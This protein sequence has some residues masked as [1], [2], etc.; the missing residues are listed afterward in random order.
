MILIDS[1]CISMYR[2]GGIAS[3]SLKFMYLSGFVWARGCIW[4]DSAR[5][6]TSELLF[7]MAIV[8][9]SHPTVTATEKYSR[10]E[11]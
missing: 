11:S 7:Y 9:W 3:S 6:L 5:R 4:A 8:R 10:R 2:V 1:R